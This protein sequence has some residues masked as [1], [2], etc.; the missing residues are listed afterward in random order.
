MPRV[1]KPRWQSPRGTDVADVAKTCRGCANHAGNQ[2]PGLCHVCCN[3]RGICK[4]STTWRRHALR[5]T[6]CRGWQHAGN[7]HRTD[8]VATCRGWRM[9]AADGNPRWQSGADVVA[10]VPPP[11][12]ISMRGGGRNCR[13]ALGVLFA[14]TCTQAI[15]GNLSATVSPKWEPRGPT[16]KP[17][18]SPQGEVHGQ[19]STAFIKGKQF[20]VLLKSN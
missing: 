5:I 17:F 9:R 19:Q 2:D 1:C 20:L 4:A 13:R 12:D 16:Q 11:S 15:P 6:P 14:Q 8:V 3:A 10:K 7:Y 18:M